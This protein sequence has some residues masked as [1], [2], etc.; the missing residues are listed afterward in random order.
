MLGSDNLDQNRIYALIRRSKSEHI[1]SLYE[2]GEVYLNTLK[3]F[4][5]DEDTES[6]KRGDSHEG[7]DHRDYI[8]EA[9]IFVCD[10]GQD[11]ETHGKLLGAAQNTVQLSLGYSGHVYCLTALSDKL[12]SENPDGY[13]F[14]ME[15]FGDKGILIHQ[16]GIFIKRLTEKLLETGYEK[17]VSNLV[18]YYPNDYTGQLNPFQKR[19]IFARQKEYRVYVPNKGDKPFKVNLGSLEDIAMIFDKSIAF[20]LRIDDRTYPFY[21]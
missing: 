15:D 20:R 11:I 13:K 14:Q 6:G 3:S 17:I 9:T 10:V 1:E 5:K 12:I 7:A 21:P 4:R 8:G 2:K 19:E 18:K 16:P